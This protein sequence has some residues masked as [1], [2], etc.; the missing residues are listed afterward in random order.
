[1]DG[2]TLGVVVILCFAALFWAIVRINKRER[3]W[4]KPITKPDP[5]RRCQGCKEL[6]WPAVS[7][8]CVPEAY[9]CERC[10]MAELEKM[11]AR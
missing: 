6:Y 8:A 2:D 5:R 9:C 7:L 11:A 1:M 10:E 3:D 4:P